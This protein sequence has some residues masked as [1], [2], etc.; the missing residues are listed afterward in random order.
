MPLGFPYPVIHTEPEHKQG[1]EEGDCEASV[2]NV[3]EGRVNE[4]DE[5]EEGV[6]VEN[7]SG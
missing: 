1:T 5:G 7:D 3:D 6:V 2:N 4:K